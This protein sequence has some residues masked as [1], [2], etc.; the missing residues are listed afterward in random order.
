VSPARSSQHGPRGERCPHGGGDPPRITDTR[1]YS[2]W[3]LTLDP[4]L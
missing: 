4:M 3:G 2:A 1:V